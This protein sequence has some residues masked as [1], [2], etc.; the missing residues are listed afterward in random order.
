MIAADLLILF[1]EFDLMMG[2]ENAE[3]LFEEEFGRRHMLVL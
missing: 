3:L 2:E 1:D